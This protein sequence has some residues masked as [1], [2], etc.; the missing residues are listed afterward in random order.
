MGGGR[1]WEASP[2]G[3]PAAPEERALALWQTARTEWLPCFHTADPYA[4]PR[5]AADGTQRFLPIASVRSLNRKATLFPFLVELKEVQDFRD[6][7]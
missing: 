5:R 3:Y 4:R 2:A 1:V 7:T 6:S